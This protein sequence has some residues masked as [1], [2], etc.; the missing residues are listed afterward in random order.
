MKEGAKL[1]L[2]RLTGVSIVLILIFVGTYSES[3]DRIIQRMNVEEN[4]LLQLEGGENGVVELNKVRLY[5]VVR[6]SDNELDVKLTNENGEEI[7]GYEPNAFEK[8]NKKPNSDGEMV[9]FPVMIFEV[10]E[11]SEYNLINEGNTT[12]WLID[13]FEIQSGLFSDNIIMLSMISCC[14]GFPLG[15]FTLIMGLFFWLRKDKNPQKLIIREEIMTTD[16]VFEKYNSTTEKDVPD[17]F[18]EIEKTLSDE[19][20]INKKAENLEQ[21]NIEQVSENWKNWDDGE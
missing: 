8:L 4:N 6:L 17:P 15:L 3:T 5:T 10:S 14:L 18:L 11:N 16:E 13:D 9:Y 12:L 7:N 21:K 20:I 19:E 1:W 2:K